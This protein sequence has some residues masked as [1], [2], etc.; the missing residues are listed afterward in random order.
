MFERGTDVNWCVQEIC[1]QRPVEL[2]ARG[3]HE[4]VVSYLLTNGAKQDELAP[5]WDDAITAA[6]ANRHIGVL[7]ILLQHGADINSRLGQCGTTPLHEAAR[8]NPVDTVRFLLEKGALLDVMQDDMV[9]FWGM[10]LFNALLRKV[11]RRLFKH[12]R[13]W[14]GMLSLSR[15]TA[16]RMTSTDHPGEDVGS[17]RHCYAVA[18]ARS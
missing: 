7:K 2:A 10:R 11:I 8:Y 5:L 9:I 4:D 1:K 12:L 6:A 16:L 17:R 3:G 13:K 14:A 18:E 15:L